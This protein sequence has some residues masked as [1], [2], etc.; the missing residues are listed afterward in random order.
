VADVGSNGLGW[1][2][3]GEAVPAVLSTGADLGPADDPQ[4]AR[5]HLRWRAR[6]RRATFVS[7]YNLPDDVVTGLRVEE[8]EADLT[9]SVE[10]LGGRSWRWRIPDHSDP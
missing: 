1:G 10:R 6:A 4:R 7:V 2:G 5:P 9:V 3:G 8:S